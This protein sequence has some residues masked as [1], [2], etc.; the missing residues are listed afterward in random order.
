VSG[1]RCCGIAVDRI[2]DRVMAH[3]HL[4]RSES[5]HTAPSTN[6][7]GEHKKRIREKQQI[8][9]NREAPLDHLLNE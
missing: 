1:Q 6:L 9:I 2:K 8:G 5:I 4:L 3:A 7:Q